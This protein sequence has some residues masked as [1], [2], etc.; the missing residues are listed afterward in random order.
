MLIWM[1]KIFWICG[2]VRF[3]WVLVT[4]LEFARTAHLTASMIKIHQAVLIKSGLSVAGLC[5]AAGGWEV[6]NLIVDYPG[7]DI[8]G[9]FS[10]AAFRRLLLP[11]PGML[12]TFTGATIGLIAI[13]R[14][15]K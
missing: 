3:K 8:G 15:R 11:E 6:G 13:R 1:H 5:A 4:K 10:P 7:N 12:L 2:A 9:A 14:K